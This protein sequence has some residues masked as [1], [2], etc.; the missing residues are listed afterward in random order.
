MAIETPRSREGKVHLLADL[1]SFYRHDRC[2][3]FTA[4]KR[5]ADELVN[6][7]IIRTECQVSIAG[8][9]RD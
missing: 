2:I 8:R 3:V 6:S 4:T 5:M 1:L 9:G 7:S